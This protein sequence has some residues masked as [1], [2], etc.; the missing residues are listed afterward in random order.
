[1]VFGRR[2][3]KQNGAVHVQSGGDTAG[4]QVESESERQKC[5]AISDVLTPFIYTC[6][7]F[8][9]CVGSVR[10]A[11]YNLFEIGDKCF[12]SRGRDHSALDDGV[13]LS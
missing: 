6:I 1:M 12:T 13:L 5:L 8:I 10:F 2:A 3:Q 9:D 4:V 7:M 11:A